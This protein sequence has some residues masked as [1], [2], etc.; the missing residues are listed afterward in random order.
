ML[1]RVKLRDFVSGG[2]CFLLH[3]NADVLPLCVIV[4]HTLL[5]EA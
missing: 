4:L 5:S 1:F 3:E 2:G